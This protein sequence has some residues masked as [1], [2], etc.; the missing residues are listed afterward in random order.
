MYTYIVMWLKS[1]F[2]TN[3]KEKTMIEKLL[4][5]L[6]RFV[7]SQEMIAKA[8]GRTTAPGPNKGQPLDDQLEEKTPPTSTY[9]TEDDRDAWLELCKERNIEV[10]SRTK[11]TT[12]I[13]KVKEFDEADPSGVDSG[14]EGPT[15]DKEEDPFDTG[16]DDQS[17]DEKVTLDQV[18]EALQKIQASSGNPAVIAILKD[19][20][21]VDKLKDLLEEKYAAVLKAATPEIKAK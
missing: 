10:P 1:I 2:T 4:E 5:L 20:G 13:K 14:P 18:R 21:G 16:S 19:P 17:S 6:E 3:R 8:F 11:T 12:L 15:D 7:V 9:P